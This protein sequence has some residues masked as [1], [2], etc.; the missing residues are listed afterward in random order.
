MERQNPFGSPE[1]EVILKPKNCRTSVAYTNYSLFFSSVCI[2]T[3]AKPAL[4]LLVFLTPENYTISVVF[5][6]K[7]CTIASPSLGLP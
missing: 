4:P 3:T 7:N 2:A 5:K 6:L 1:V